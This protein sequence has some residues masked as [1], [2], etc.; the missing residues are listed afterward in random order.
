MAELEY[1]NNY[2]FGIKVSNETKVILLYSLGLF[3]FPFL[4]TQQLILGTLIN[5]LLIKSSI[6]CKSKKVLL[7][8]VV[9]SIA[10]LA[11]GYVFGSLTYHVIYML[12]FIWAG[13]LVL[14]IAMRK[15]FVESKQNYLLSALIGAS[16]K[17]MLLF[18]IAFVLMTYSFVPAVFLTVFGIVQF[19]TAT[20]GAMIVYATRIVQSSFLK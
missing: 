20:L 15:L 2:L 16:A 17:T 13:N 19:V 3:I 12:P 9:P 6:D 7:L 14:M 8:S 18:S 10:V 5:A 1:K 11:S 4:I